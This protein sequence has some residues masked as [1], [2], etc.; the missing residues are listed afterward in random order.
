[1]LHNYSLLSTSQDS[2]ILRIIWVQPNWARGYKAQSH[3]LLQDLR[4]L[5][6]LASN[7]SSHRDKEIGT[8][9]NKCQ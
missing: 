1:M 9:I 5:P 3:N 2:N 4:I 8:K 7:D 6:N